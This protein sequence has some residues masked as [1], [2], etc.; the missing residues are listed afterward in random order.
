MSDLTCQYGHDHLSG[1][2][3]YQK[4]HDEVDIWRKSFISEQRLRLAAEAEVARYRE[5]FGE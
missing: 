1:P 5:R 3:P 4:C 2:C